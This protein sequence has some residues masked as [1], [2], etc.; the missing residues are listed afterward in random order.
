[1][2]LMRIGEAG[3][4][5]PVFVST[6][7]QAYDLRPVTA[8]IDG[9]FLEN[10]THRLDELPFEAL[11][12][13]DT[14]GLRIGAPIA[15]PGAVLGIGL[16]YAGH[17]AESGNPIPERPIV[18]Y[19]HPNT[20][21][22]PNDDV[23]IPPRAEKVDWEAE[24][25]VVIGRRASYLASP[26]DAGAC[27]AGYVLAN[28]ISEREFQLEHS[29]AQWTLGKS[30]PTFTP[31]GPW[32]VPAAEVHAAGDSGVRLQT[33]VNGNPRQ[34]SFTADMVFDAVE[35][36][37]RLSQYM[38]LEPGDLINT[39]T[40]EGVAMSGRFPYLQEGDTLTLAGG[41][42]GEQESKV[43]QHELIVPKT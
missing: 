14:A 27:I 35:L 3:Q 2:K 36:V 38:V 26:A 31:V 33:W 6:E 1:M 32:L 42:L 37:Y 20:V 24:L 43:H 39:G 16:N 5:V 7:G 23:V 30:C 25:G 34:D 8:D 17:A 21:I 4:E 41:I 13:I 9:A 10:W 29:G 22:G 18:F 40:P 28:D 12:P 15:R 11:A 19:K